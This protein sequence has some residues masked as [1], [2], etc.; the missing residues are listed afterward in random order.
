MLQCDVIYTKICCVSPLQF[1]YFYTKILHKIIYITHTDSGHVITSQVKA[2]NDT[3]RMVLWFEVII[4]PIKD[5]LDKI[6]I[7]CDNCGSHKTS[8][9]TDVIDE[10]GAVVCLLPKI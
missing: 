4:K 6:L 1:I 7:L 9:V 8:S 5:K 2:W 3:V 10:I